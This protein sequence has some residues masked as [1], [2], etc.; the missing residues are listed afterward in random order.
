MQGEHSRGL[1]QDAEWEKEE[2]DKERKR[3]VDIH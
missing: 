2:S 1:T 3:I